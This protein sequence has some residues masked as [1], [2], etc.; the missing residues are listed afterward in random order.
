MKNTTARLHDHWRETIQEL[1]AAIVQ[2]L[3]C[4]LARDKVRN[5]AGDIVGFENERAVMTAKMIEHDLMLEVDLTGEAPRR[6]LDGL[7]VTTF[8]GIGTGGIDGRQILAFFKNGRALRVLDYRVVRIEDA[9]ERIARELAL[10]RRR[11]GEPQAPGAGM[12]TV[13]AAAVYARVSE[14]TIRTWAKTT[15][16]NGP[17]LPNAVG[18][19]RLLRI[20]KRDLEPYRKP[21]AKSTGKHSKPKTNPTRKS[22]KRK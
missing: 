7:F 4:R 17:M 11:T 6:G 16:G 19:G 13:A 12:M 20:H 10:A 15:D 9:S 22:V 3:G 2:D 8:E 21:E 18:K 1:R 5:A 14:K